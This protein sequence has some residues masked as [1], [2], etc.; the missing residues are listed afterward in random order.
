MAS[1]QR[2]LGASGAVGAPFRRAAGAPFRSAGAHHWCAMEARWWLLVR[3]AGV[4]SDA[5]PG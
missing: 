5:V 4:A 3:A 1:L 2:R